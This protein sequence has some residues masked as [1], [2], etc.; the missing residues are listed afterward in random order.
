MFMS[1]YIFRDTKLAEQ[2]S[3]NAVGSKQQMLYLLFMNIVT[4]ATMASTL[5]IISWG[6]SDITIYNYVLDTVNILGIALIIY[7]TYTINI[8]GD[9]QN[10]IMRFTCLN[11]PIAIKTALL[12]IIL[13]AAGGA[14]D[15]ILATRS[16]P[17]NL[18]G[19]D[20]AQL[21]QIAQY[22]LANSNIGPGAIAAI[23][24]ALL[25]ALRRFVV[26]FK[27][28]NNLTQKNDA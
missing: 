16:N 26:C 14:I 4:T 25:Y 9:G 23:I 19:I 1:V 8:R 18:P 7:I 5:G 22:E 27:I 24:L 15:V 3:Q 20:Q 28:V 10:F 12:T 2:L 17:N 13:G 11:F 21:E 6:Q